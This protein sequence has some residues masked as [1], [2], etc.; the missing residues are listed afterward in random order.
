MIGSLFVTQGHPVTENNGDSVEASQVMPLGR[1]P[2]SSARTNADNAKLRATISADSA[3]LTAQ[4]SD[5]EVNHIIAGISNKFCRGTA[6]VSMFLATQR[7][8]ET[9]DKIY[10]R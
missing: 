10:P 1:V 6:S 7:D 4:A 5:P 9:L 3:L 2:A 8:M